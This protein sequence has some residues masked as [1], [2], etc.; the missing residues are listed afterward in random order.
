MIHLFKII[1]EALRFNCVRSTS[2]LASDKYFNMLRILPI[3]DL[4]SRNIPHAA[5]MSLTKQ[6]AIAFCIK[7]VMFRGAKGVEITLN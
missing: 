4:C 2:S 5:L 1:R 3:A 6:L 7:P